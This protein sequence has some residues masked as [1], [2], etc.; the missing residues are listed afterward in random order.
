MS[1]PAPIPCK[2]DGDSFSPLPRFDR[3]ADARFVIGETYNLAAV[4]DRSDASHR[5]EFAWLREA[6]QSLPESLSDQF[7]S[8]EHLRK[9]ALIDAG[10]YDEQIVDAG[11]NRAALRVAAAFR[12]REEFALVI[13]R[14][15]YV[16]I[17]TAKSQTRRAMD[18]AEFQRS[19]TA[20][21]ETI[22]TLIGVTPEALSEHARAA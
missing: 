10:F 12:T 6:W 16:F 17:R 5:H 13:V 22:A 3:Q 2:W 1:A 11:T 21:M 19:K 4:E 7:P 15:G 18:K 14:G 9:R 20:I 8:P